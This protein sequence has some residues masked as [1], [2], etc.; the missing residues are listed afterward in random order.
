MRLTLSTSDVLEAV[1]V[2]EIGE[3]EGHDFSIGEEFLASVVKLGNEAGSVK[4]RVNHPDGQGDVLSIVGEASNFRLGDECVLADVNLFDVPDKSRLVTLAR[5]AGHLFG[6]SL[7]FAGEVVKKAGQKI[8]TMTC[9]AIYGVDFVDT[10]AAT[11]ALFSGVSADKQEGRYR[12]VCVLAVDS[13]KQVKGDH[14]PK[15]LNKRTIK[16]E[17]APPVVDE[18][19]DEP[20]GD[21]GDPIADVLAKLTGIEERLTKLETPPE[22]DE[23]QLEDDVP[24]KEEELE[25]CGDDEVAEEKMATMAAKVCS[26]MLAKVGVRPRS[27]RP[28]ADDQPAETKLSQDEEK[29]MT[30]LSMGDEERKQFAANLAAAKRVKM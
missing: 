27:S 2:V 16:L 10:P 11:R 20:D 8:K 4:V 14:M 6:M 30:Q 23:T 5:Q 19:H 17:D 24:A 25:D 28:E 3:A 18:T 26:I 12:T 22:E 21:E 7:D 15:T 9:E 1:R 29:L 13:T